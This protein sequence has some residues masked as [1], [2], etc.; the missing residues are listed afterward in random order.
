[1][2]FVETGGVD[3]ESIDDLIVFVRQIRRA[4]LDAV[5]HLDVV[6]IWD[7]KNANFAFDVVSCISRKAP[8]AGDTL[9][10][11][12]AQ[13]LNDAQLAVMRRRYVSGLKSVGVYGQFKSLQQDIGLRSKIEYAIGVKPTPLEPSRVLHPYFESGVP[14]LGIPEH[15][16]KDKEVTDRNILL[17]S[18]PLK[19]VGDVMAL[20]ALA[21]TPGLR[22]IVLSAGGMK[23][24][25]LRNH[26]TDVT[27]YHYSELPADLFSGLADIAVL[28]QTAPLNYRSKSIVANML[29]SGCVV[30]DAS[31]GSTHYEF[32]KV[33]VRTA[34]NLAH[35]KEH[36][37]ETVLP[38]FAPTSKA[39]LE[40]DLSIAV[41]AVEC[42]EAFKRQLGYAG[43]ASKSKDATVRSTSKKA[44][45]KPMVLYHPTNGNG[46]GHA[47]RC[48]LVASQHDRSQFDPC[49]A[50]FSSCIPMLTKS[51][52]DT[53]PLVSRTN[54]HKTRFS[55]DLL[56]FSR[57]L[58]VVRDASAFVFDGGYIFDSVVRSI[59]ETRTPAAWI[60]RGLWQETQNNIAP[61]D[62]EKFFKL[63]IVPQ[64]AFPE[65]NDSYSNGDQVENVG[66]IVNK[67][68]LKTAKRKNIRR[69]LAKALDFEFETLVVTMLGGGV[70][71]DRA[72]Q[73]QMLCSIMEERENTLHVAVIWP[74]ARLEPSLFHWRNTQIVR[75]HFA[76]PLIASSDLFVSAVGYNSFH[77]ALY[78]QIPTIFV[79]QMSATMDDQEKR[80]R[81]AAE[82]GLAGLIPASEFSQM[83]NEVEKFLDAGHGAKVRKALAATALPETGNARAAQIIEELASNV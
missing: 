78:N 54:A 72:M 36:L 42:V 25:W 73:L 70:A 50:A 9:L 75:T 63:V 39:T 43:A 76:L 46:L 10:I 44:P 69:E 71:A 74:T 37:L 51:G 26:G 18:P 53:F 24:E 12:N 11:V 79:P 14:I 47:Q 16:V 67:L 2:I 82:R 30:L 35:L 38:V 52:F 5:L 40:S 17:I 34:Q 59:A 15:R 58:P 83:E 56:N 13:K 29:R 66:P 68:E 80:A 31:L 8:K 60:R 21:R 20:K 23:E 45:K 3:A 1:M 61:L 32:S 22:P 41:D 6:S 4:G 28:Y 77:E 19:E 27:F 57:L 33:F 64:E 55:H 62:R 7:G 81:A 49:F 65:L 48:S